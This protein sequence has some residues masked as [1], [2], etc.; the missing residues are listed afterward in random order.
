MVTVAVTIVGFILA[1]VGVGIRGEIRDI[2]VVIIT[3]WIRTMQAVRRVFTGQTIERSEEE[4]AAAT[5]KGRDRPK[6]W[7]PF[8]P[9]IL[10]GIL[11][12]WWYLD[13]QGPLL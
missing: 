5:V 12:G 7:I 4:L 1:M 11:L 8:A 13:T 6:G 10:G 3:G 9:A 2:P